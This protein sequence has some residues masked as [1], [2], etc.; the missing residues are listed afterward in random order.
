[1][2]TPIIPVENITPLTI[3][4][5]ELEE[6][7]LS[8][9]LPTTK[10]RTSIKTNTITISTKPI[11]TKVITKEKLLETKLTN[12][13]LLLPIKATV[14]AT[15]KKNSA[16]SLQHILQDNEKSKFTDEESQENNEISREIDQ[17]ATSPGFRPEPPGYTNTFMFTT[18]TTTKKIPF[19]K[20]IENGI[21]VNF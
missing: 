20:V 7:L 13:K 3:S 17:T 15:I 16:V 18:I 2:S 19:S 8:S 5:T 9:L 11:T 4:E 6:E 10:K 1:M 12:T 21:V 14:T